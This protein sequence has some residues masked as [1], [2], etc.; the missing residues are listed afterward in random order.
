MLLLHNT[1]NVFFFGFLVMLIDF[2]LLLCNYRYRVFGDPP[3]QRAA[4][5]IAYSVAR[6][7]SRNGTLVNY[8]M[9]GRYPT[10]FSFFLRE[11]INLHEEL[12]SLMQIVRIL[13]RL[14]NC[15]PYGSVP[16][17]LLMQHSCLLY[18]TPSLCL[19]SVG[20]Y[21]YIYYTEI[22]FSF[23]SLSV[24][25]F[26]NTYHLTSMFAVPWWDKLWQNKRSLY[27]NSLL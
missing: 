10:F 16:I 9:V 19:L 25:L 4:E 20:L 1:R 3:S 24:S 11:S 5:D 6:F 8:Y 12:F 27:N 7:F 17:V 23:H 26:L 15:R 14:I 18:I 21:V 13:V 22:E 2:E